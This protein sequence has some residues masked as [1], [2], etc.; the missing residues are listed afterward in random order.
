MP[1]RPAERQL[2]FAGFYSHFLQNNSCPVK[3]VLSFYIFLVRLFVSCVWI[4]Y[5]PLN[6]TVANIKSQVI[7]YVLMI[8]MIIFS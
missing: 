6:S 5:L 8:Y 4:S 3:N 7:S 1:L 2:D